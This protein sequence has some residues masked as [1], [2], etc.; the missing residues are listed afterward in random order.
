MAG[1]QGRPQNFRHESR[2]RY[3]RCVLNPGPSLLLY[4]VF[5]PLDDVVNTAQRA[6]SPLKP[7]IQ[8]SVAATEQTDIG[9][10]IKEGIDRFSE[11]MPLLMN[12]QD[13][14][15]TLHP[16]IGGVFIL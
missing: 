3:S 13:E 12:A 1:D 7:I 11:G 9:K 10:S 6:V 16:F 15:R 14:H 4:A 5:S 8:A 2:A